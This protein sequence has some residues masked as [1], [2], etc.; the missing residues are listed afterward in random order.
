MSPDHLAAVVDQLTS[1]TPVWS[2][3]A[4]IA[5]M[6]SLA[7]NVK[8]GLVDHPVGAAASSSIVGAV[9]PLANLVSKYLLYHSNRLKH[10]L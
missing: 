3:V 1:K 8:L 7:D 5:H 4:V 10:R 2:L 6:Y 9:V